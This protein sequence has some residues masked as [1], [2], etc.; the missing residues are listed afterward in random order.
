MEPL[1]PITLTVNVPV[2]APGL[3]VTVRIELAVP[4][5][6]TITGEVTI[7]VTL[8]GVFPSQAASR[9]TG[10]LNPFTEFIAIV[11]E[12]LPPCGNV[13]TDV[14]EA[15]VKSAKAEVV[16]V[17]VEAVVVA[18]LLTVRVAEEESPVDPVAV[19]V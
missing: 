1:V 6:V 3:A 9:V 7:M 13:T 16:A 14:G 2:D 19:T 10:A 11:A 18:A 5:D 15:I 12:A 4:P 17:E 8:A